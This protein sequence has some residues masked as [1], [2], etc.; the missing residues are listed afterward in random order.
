MGTIQKSFHLVELSKN[1]YAKS[2]GSA[3]S[4]SG[5]GDVCLHNNSSF[6]LLW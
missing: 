1:G 5:G 3:K 4:D 6:F 2:K